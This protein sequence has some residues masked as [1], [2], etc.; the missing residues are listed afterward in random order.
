[1]TYSYNN[2]LKIGIQALIYKAYFTFMFMTWLNFHNTAIL[3]I[4]L[5]TRLHCSTDN[6][7]LNVFKSKLVVRIN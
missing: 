6:V 7:W 2:Q 4:C 5:N 1:M 3:S